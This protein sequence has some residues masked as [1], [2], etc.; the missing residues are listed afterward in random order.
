MNLLVPSYVVPISV[1]VL[2]ALSF[3]VTAHLRSNSQRRQYYFL[4]GITLLG[5]VFGAKISVLFGDYHWPWTQVGDWG[6]VLW[7]GR[8]I[9]GALIF[10]FLFA[11]IAKPLI[12]YHI[13]PNDRFATL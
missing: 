8:S 5:A 3:P 10:G 2:L 13:P 11:E 4:Q 7:S 1:S 9:T 12:R 6:P